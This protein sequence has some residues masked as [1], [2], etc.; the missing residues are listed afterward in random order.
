MTLKDVKEYKIK[1]YLDFLIQGGDK[2]ML[3]D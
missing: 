1:Y 2:D 3:D